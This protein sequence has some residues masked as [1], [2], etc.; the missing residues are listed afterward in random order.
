MRY[1]KFGKENRDA[2][3]IIIGLMRI[4]K[5][6][7]GEV[8]N[9]IDAALDVGINFLDIADIYTFGISRRLSVT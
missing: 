8:K 4:S 2:S 6:T 5:M 3:E 9:L 1:I 7:P